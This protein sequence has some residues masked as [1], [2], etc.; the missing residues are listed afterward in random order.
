MKKTIELRDVFKQHTI[1]QDKSLAPEETIKRFKD[2]LKN[3]NLDILEGTAR[4]DSG[5]LDIPVFFSICGKHAESIIG[6]RKQMGKGATP[7]QAEASAVMELAERFSFFSFRHNPQHFFVGPYSHVADRAIPFRM[8]AQSVH[9][10]SD[11]LEITK[12]FFESLPLKWVKALNL[13]REKE[14]LVPFDWFFMINEFNGACAGNCAEEAICQGICEVV[15]RHVSSIISRNRSQVPGIDPASADDSMVRSMLE[16]YARN[17]IS[18][19]LSD[20]TLDVGIPSVGI[21]AY[22]LSTFPQ[23]SEI[24]WT[25]G[26][27]PDPQK[28]LGRALSEVAQLAGDFNSG[29]N[30]VASGLPKL[31]SLAEAE[32]VT[33]VDKKTNIRDLPDLSSPNFKIEVQN[34]VAA[35]NENGMDVIVI[36]IG[37]PALAIPAFYIIVPGAHFRERSLKASVGLFTAKFMAENRPAAE[38]LPFLME[39]DR[40]LPHKYYVQFYIA[41]CYHSL[42]RPDTAL[43]Y[44]QKALGLQPHPQ[45]L[46]SIYSYSGLCLKEMGRYHEA[47]EVLSEG[48][49]I[50]DER[51]DLYNL[52]GFCYFKLK[53]YENAIDCFKKVLQLNPASAIDYANIAS[54]YRDMGHPEKAIHYYEQALALDPSIEFAQENLKRLWQG[55]GHGR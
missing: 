46:A 33:H 25:A 7:L 14:V 29:S 40:K 15:E 44:Y 13:T 17:Q 55:A 47:L 49:K 2:K 41:S 31:K 3:C 30:Y 28:A 23:K 45:D 21:L 1:D 35:L 38:A 16:K 54:N 39:L 19:Y 9:D 24:V 26:T 37:S 52:M 48:A 43:T 11:E 32:F 22:D 50:D 5:R 18:L 20:F 12:P 4:I 8:I 51:T 6:S 27:A 42:E 10:N 53:Q 34:C 36:D